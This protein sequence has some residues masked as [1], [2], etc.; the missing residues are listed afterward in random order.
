MKNAKMSG[1]M[2]LA[3]GF[4]TSGVPNNIFVEWRWDTNEK[5]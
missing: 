2:D 5:G 4:Y 3:S 1:Y